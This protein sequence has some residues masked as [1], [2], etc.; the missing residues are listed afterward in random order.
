MSRFEAKEGE[1]VRRGEVI[2]YVGSTGFAT[3]PHLHWQLTVNG[4]PVNPH[5]WVQ[6]IE[7]C[8]AP[9]AAK[10][11]VAKKPRKPHRSR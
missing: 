6:G 5:Q 10:K 2:G 8:A 9:P 4:V 3:G 7:P 1:R 11:S